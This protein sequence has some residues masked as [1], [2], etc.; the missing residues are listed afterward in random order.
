MYLSKK[1]K[2]FQ[3]SSL[4]KKRRLS[5]MLEAKEKFFWENVLGRIFS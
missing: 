4:T 5:E 3:I 2:I 1:G